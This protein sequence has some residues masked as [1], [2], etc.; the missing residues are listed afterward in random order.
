MPGNTVTGST[1]AI[2]AGL[3]DQVTM[4][5]QS[6]AMAQPQSPKKSHASHTSPVK[7]P[8]PSTVLINSGINGVLIVASP[9]PKPMIQPQSPKKTH[10]QPSESAVYN[11]LDEKDFDI[12]DLLRWFYINADFFGAPFAPGEEGKAFQ[13]WAQDKKHR[14]QMAA[15]SDDMYFLFEMEC[16]GKFSQAIRGTPKD[17]GQDLFKGEFLDKGLL[18]GGLNSMGQLMVKLAAME[19]PKEEQKNGVRTMSELRRHMGD[20]IINE[21]Y[22]TQATKEQRNRREERRKEL[23]DPDALFEKWN[24]EKKNET[25]KKAL[26]LEIKE[27]KIIKWESD[28]NVTVSQPRVVWKEKSKAEKAEDKAEGNVIGIIRLESQGYRTHLQKIIQKELMK[29]GKSRLPPLPE[30]LD[31]YD[32]LERCD[33]LKDALDAQSVENGDRL[34]IALKKYA[35]M[36]QGE[37]IL[38]GNGD[39]K[40]RLSA[41]DQHMDSHEST[42]Q[43][44]KD[45]EFVL[46]WQRICLTLKKSLREK[47]DS[48]DLFRMF[49]LGMD[50]RRKLL[51][52]KPAI[53]TTPSPRPL[54]A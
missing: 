16:I 28:M 42:L 12:A 38:E 21:W 7:R 52:C 41:Y 22:K 40:S 46:F 2:E 47:M 6:K 19:A 5:P 45:S 29:I 18:Q 4:P 35:I 15:L 10:A 33:V 31:R 8:L 34:I 11:Y 26:A 50:S 20:L 49:T 23:L 1:F 24:A 37:K 13:K 39:R 53:L 25:D 27:Q 43:Q 51:P 17:N 36:R 48:G 30:L 9:Q 54:H 3:K 32:S 14:D 44:H